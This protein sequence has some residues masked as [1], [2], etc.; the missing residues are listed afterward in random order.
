MLPIYPGT[1]AEE[2]RMKRRNDELDHE[3]RSTIRW[4]FVASV[5]A[6]I[7]FVLLFT[8]YRPLPI[9]PF[10]A[11]GPRTGDDRAAAGG[12][13]ELVA[14]RA[15]ASTP[16]PSEQVIIIETPPEPTPVPEI[17]EIEMPEPQPV[18][19]TIAGGE[20]AGETGA[21]RGERTGPG[22]ATGT[23]TGDGGTADEG[24]FRVVAPTPRGLILPPSD[25]PGRVRGR[26]V[27]VWVF[28]S[29]QGRVVPDSTR[30]EPGTGDNRFDGRLREQAAQGR[31]EPARRG[32]QPVAE[33]FRYVIIL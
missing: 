13:L 30:L 31:F 32:G 17:A 7:L 10:A 23:G 9:S 2:Q 28:V 29:S 27:A 26:E 24:R 22:I 8:S 15:V 25:R 1:M 3:Y 4:A 12:G 5:L 18:T 21:G 14:I 19:A 33:W 20:T 16:E 11:A 6:H